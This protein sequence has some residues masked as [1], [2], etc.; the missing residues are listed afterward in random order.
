MSQIY[1]ESR[2]GSA[3]LLVHNSLSINTIRVTDANGNAV[4]APVLKRG[5]NGLMLDAANLQRWTPDTPVLYTFQADNQEPF[6]FGFCS[7]ETLGN[8][9]VLVNGHPYY[10]RGYIRG[11]VAHDHP[12]LTGGSDYEAARKNILQ[13]KKFGFNLVRF[14]S[15]V[16]SPEFV[17][18]ADE[19]G[20]FIHAEIGFAYE[21]GADGK[22]T[23][24]ALDNRNWRETILRYRNSPS[25]MIFC[26]GNEMH[27]SGHQS[28][29]R[30]LYEEG[31]ALAPGKL[32][33]DNSGW[34]EFDRDT[35]D[36]YSQHI[37]Y[38]FPFKKHRDMFFGDDHWHVNGSVNDAPMTYEKAASKSAAAP[39]RCAR[40]W[41]TK[42]CITTTSPI[43][44]R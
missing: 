35:A 19:L 23:D 44:T 12:N 21:Y 18:A 6:T 37:A 9:H 26:I 16:P 15:T 34:G 36:I 2:T 10:F 39:T 28:K 41:P 30:K 42:R 11:I 25:L 31:K 32:I 8:T 24:L 14:H 22:R 4:E 43:M 1:L 17:R 27:Q 20:I 38:Y 5:E 7:F 3:E 13:A 29:V 40:C 33:M